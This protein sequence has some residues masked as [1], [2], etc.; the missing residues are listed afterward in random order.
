MTTA[1]LDVI[2]PGPITQRTGGYIYDARMVDGLRGLGW[3]VRVHELAGHFPDGGGGGERALRDT[4]AAIADGA[5]VLTDGLA[6]GALP[7]PVREAA[8][9]L[10]LVALVHH[11]LGDETG[12]DAETSERWLRLEVDT[13]AACRGVVVT[14]RFTERRLAG[15]GVPE[16]RI[17]VVRPGTDPASGPPEPEASPPVLLTV[18]AVVPRKGQLDLARALVRLVE[19]PWTWVCLGSLGRDPAYAAAVRE[20]LDAGGL[21]SRV[22]WLGECAPETVRQW[23]RRASVFVMPSHY[24]GYGMA[25]A[26]AVAYGVPVVSTTGGAIPDTVPAAA[27][28]L[29][30]PG[31][32]DALCL[33]LSSLLSPEGGT[34]RRAALAAAARA[35]AARLPSWTDMVATFAR[36][37]EELTPDG[38]L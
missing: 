3:D 36:A 22:R 19:L 31:N 37:L 28:V 8:G 11:P 6:V 33:A 23:Y 16:E 9:R 5:R 38:A 25:L 2:V 20:C 17:R 18:G 32:E 35:E 14:S 1:E 4:L 10:R 26:D 15:L 29:V 24:E 7:G 27:A 12:L 13:L 30:P 34:P 21:S